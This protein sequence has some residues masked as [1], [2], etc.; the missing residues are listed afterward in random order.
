[1]C[2]ARA[3]CTAQCTHLRQRVAHVPRAHAQ[4]D[5]GGR[6]IGAVL[7]HRVRRLGARGLIGKVESVAVEA[8][9]AR[10]R[11]V[12]PAVALALGPLL[13][14]A[15]HILHVEADW[16]GYVPLVPQNV[17]AAGLG[18]ANLKQHLVA[19]AWTVPP[20]PRLDFEISSEGGGLAKVA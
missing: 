2:G 18:A 19:L 6:L 3:V 12:Q 4:L 8:E 1:M 11:H 10:E 5:L 9:F 16:F 14:D 15:V 20:P 7:E 17:V 13:L